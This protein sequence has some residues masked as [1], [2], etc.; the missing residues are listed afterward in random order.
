MSL[1][2]TEGHRDLGR[3][4]RDFAGK[5]ELIRRARAAFTTSPAEL[6]SAFSAMTDLGWT[7]LHLPADHGG[8]GSGLAELAVVLDELGAAVAP[9]PF[10]ASVIGSAIIS[11]LGGDELRQS[12]LP[13]AAAGTSVIA[14][15]M[16]SAVRAWLGE[17]GHFKRPAPTRRATR[18]GTWPADA[19]HEWRAGPGP[20]T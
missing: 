3:V 14:Y 2:I 13:G 9:G 16:G 12:L 19:W 10:L 8:S 7:G 18:A 11:A 15:G 17:D 5:S 4:V 1:A 20:T 6:D